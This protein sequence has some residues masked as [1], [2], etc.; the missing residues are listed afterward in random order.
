VK[1]LSC[2]EVVEILNDYLEGVMP[3]ADRA[4]LERHLAVCA[5]CADYLDQLRTT[6]R[7]VGRL[8][9]DT[10]PAEATAPLIETFRAWRQER[11]GDA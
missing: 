4:S 1:E 10:V 2:R 11:A 7:L 3:P 8:T 6:V 5:G 9:E